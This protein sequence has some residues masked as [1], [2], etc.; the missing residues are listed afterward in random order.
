MLGL[1]SICHP[2]FYDA[3][4]CC[5]QSR[6]LLALNDA[7]GYDDTVAVKPIDLCLCE[8]ASISHCDC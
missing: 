3:V 2:F 6:Q 5:A 1:G 7:P 8:H 4:G